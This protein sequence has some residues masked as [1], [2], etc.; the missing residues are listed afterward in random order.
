MIHTIYSTIFADIKSVNRRKSRRRRECVVCRR[1]INKEDEYI[2][3]LTRY[4][5]RL[6]TYSMH[7]D[8]LNPTPRDLTWYKT[9]KWMGFTLVAVSAFIALVLYYLEAK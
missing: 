4:D 9:V 7:E 8:C 3:M 6:I 2:N 5:N 1:H